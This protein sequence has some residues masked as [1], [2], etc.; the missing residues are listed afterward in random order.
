[1]TEPKRLL[2][3]NS[4]WLAFKY[5]RLDKRSPLRSMIALA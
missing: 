1:M 2:P 5:G 4:E 3:N